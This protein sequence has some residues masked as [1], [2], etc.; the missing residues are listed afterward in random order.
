M[1]AANFPIIVCRLY[2]STTQ[3]SLDSFFCECVSTNVSARKCVKQNAHRKKPPL[4]CSKTRNIMF[5]C[6]FTNP[7]VFAVK[8]CQ[9]TFAR[10]YVCANTLKKKV[11]RLCWEVLWYNRQTI[12]GKFA[13]VIRLF[14]KAEQITAF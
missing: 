7:W 10:S 13:A 3:H 9:F 11:S 12:I 8:D 1:T 2:R 14:L 4:F 6:L 5:L